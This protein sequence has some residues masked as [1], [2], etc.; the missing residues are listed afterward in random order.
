MLHHVVHL[1]P[2]P[3]LVVVLVEVVILATYLVQQHWRTCGLRRLLHRLYFALL[4][5]VLA[6]RGITLA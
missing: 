6:N 4:F 1:L 2:E 3:F 5:A